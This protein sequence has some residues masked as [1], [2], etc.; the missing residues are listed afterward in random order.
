MSGVREDCCGQGLQNR[1][2]RVMGSSLEC[3][4]TP[5]IAL[6]LRSNRIS[7]MKISSFLE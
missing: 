4:Q 6:V 1:V 5:P 7:K 2:D 3:V